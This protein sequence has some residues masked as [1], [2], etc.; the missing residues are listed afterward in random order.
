MSNL[1]VI[2][3]EMGKQISGCDVA[4]EFITDVILKKYGIPYSV[5]FDPVFLSKETD[6][7]IYSAAHTG[8]E[9]QIVIE[10]K[11]RNQD[12]VSSQNIG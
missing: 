1:A 11:K 7:V 5:G 12:S 9:N 10:A 6:L 4:E 2:L 8:Q 3:K